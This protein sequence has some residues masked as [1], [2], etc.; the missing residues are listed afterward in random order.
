MVKKK[1][2]PQ[3]VK[4]KEPWSAKIILAL[5]AVAVVLIIGSA[6]AFSIVRG[7]G[8]NITAVGIGSVELPPKILK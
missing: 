4:K 6:I 1:K 5:G 7:G 3:V 8:A 2:A